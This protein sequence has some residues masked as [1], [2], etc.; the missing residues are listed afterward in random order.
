MVNVRIKPGQRYVAVI[1]VCRAS[2][3]LG[4]SFFGGEQPRSC[5]AVLSRLPVR[6]WLG[7]LNSTVLYLVFWLAAIK[8]EL[9]LEAAVFFL[10]GYLPYCGCIPGGTS[11]PF[12]G[13]E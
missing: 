11:V 1:I 10:T 8:T 4:L 3:F 7:L 5:V 6:S 2:F 13:L 12:L 9:L